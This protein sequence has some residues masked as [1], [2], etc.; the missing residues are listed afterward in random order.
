[1]RLWDVRS[2]ANARAV[3]PGRYPVSSVAFSPDGLTLASADESGYITLWDLATRSPRRV[4]NADDDE[5][6]ALAFSPDG[7]T[8]A[9]AGVS[10]DGPALGPRHRAGAADPGR[11]PRP[12]QRPGVLPRRRH[13][14]FGRSRRASTPLSR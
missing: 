3:L 7:R 14:H 2:R 8:L 11:E 4:I 12:G 9:S 6:R 5:V 10:R 1:M 13:A